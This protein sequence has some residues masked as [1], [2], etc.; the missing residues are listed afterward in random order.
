LIYARAHDQAVAEDY[1]SAM[2]R[3]EQ[4]LE[5]A[6]VSKPEPETEYEVIKVPEPAQLLAWVEQ[7]AL[8]DLCKEERLEIAGSLKRALSLDNASLRPPPQVFATVSL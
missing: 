6:P 4:R 8:P 3:V 5:I 2:S 1:F 7:L